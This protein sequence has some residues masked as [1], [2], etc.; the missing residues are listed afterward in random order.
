MSEN[1]SFYLKKIKITNSPKT[2]MNGIYKSLDG[3]ESKE[4]VAIAN[5]KKLNS[6]NH[7]I[8]LLGNLVTVIGPDYTQVK[9]F[10]DIN[11]FPLTMEDGTIIHREDPKLGR[12][13]VGTIPNLYLVVGIVLVV[14][15]IILLL[16]LI[17]KSS[18]RLLY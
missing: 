14:I 6:D 15:I 18:N 4:K 7:I 12:P 9:Y 16:M 5:F 10:N 3:I 8:H 13:W 17:G 2:F 1:I 11:K